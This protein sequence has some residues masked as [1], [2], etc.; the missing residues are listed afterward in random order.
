VAK[1][2]L[3]SGLARKT[4]KKSRWILLLKVCHAQSTDIRKDRTVGHQPVFRPLG[5]DGLAEKVTFNLR[6]SRAPS[7]EEKCKL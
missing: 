7:V 6:N 5:D 1:F 4:A 3:G 2:D